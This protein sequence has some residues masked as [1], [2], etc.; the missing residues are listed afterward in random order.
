MGGGAEDCKDRAVR[1]RLGWR[2][3]TVLYIN[4][5]CCALAGGKLPLRLMFNHLPVNTDARGVASM[6]TAQGCDMQ[7]NGQR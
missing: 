6:G 1:E 2:Q 7:G 5:L 4:K 3:G